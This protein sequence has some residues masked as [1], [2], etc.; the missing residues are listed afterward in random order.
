MSAER[1]LNETDRNLKNFTVLKKDAIRKAPSRGANF[2][3][4]APFSNLFSIIIGTHFV[5]LLQSCNVTT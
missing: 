5:T 1:N 4:V 3:S 2:S